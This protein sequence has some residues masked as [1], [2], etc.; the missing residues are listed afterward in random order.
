MVFPFLAALA[1]FAPLIG[2]GVS[3]VGSFLSAKES[4]KPRTTT[5]EI[6]YVKLRKSAE[7]AG[8]NPL[9]A[10]RNG[11][12]AGFQVT[13]SPALSGVSPIGEGLQA[14]GGL[15]ANFDWSG[16]SQRRE[17]AEYELMLAQIDNIQTDTARMRSMSFDVP[18]GVGPNMG[19]S[20]GSVKIA[21]PEELVSYRV[22]GVQTKPHPGWSNAQ[23]VSDRSGDLIEW[24]YGV[25]VTAA[26]WANT[27]GI[28][29]EPPEHLADYLSRRKA[30][31][32][33]DDFFEKH[34]YRVGGRF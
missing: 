1:P 2:A 26:D 32:Q 29:M 18:T 13:H 25:G 22:A 19:R 4:S 23:E 5:S 28:Q 14:V 11:G 17:Q 10:L 33:S 7:A 27:F 31:I 20:D 12:G 34:G 16:Q 8:F 21:P 9:T 24:I 3:A 30:E 6:D 15:V